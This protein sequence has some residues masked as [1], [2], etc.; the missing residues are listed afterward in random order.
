MKRQYNKIIE[1]TMLLPFIALIAIIGYY[2]YTAYTDYVSINELLNPEMI[3]LSFILLFSVLYIFFIKRAFSKMAHEDKLLHDILMHFQ[4]Y[5][6]IEETYQI[7]E[8]LVKLNKIKIYQF[9][10]KIIDSLEERRMDSDK[11]N[12]SK[13]LFL[14]NMSHEIRTPLNGIVGFTDL[15]RSSD[16]NSEQDEYVEIVQKSSENLLSIINDILDISKIEN[17]KVELECIEFD[18]ILE[19]ESGI[20]SY[21]AKASEKKIDLGFF[22]DPTLSY[23]KLIGDPSKIKQILVNLISNAVKFT[24]NGGKINIQIE[25]VASNEGIS[26]IN[27]S[28]SD[29]GIGIKPEHKSKI[30]MPFSQADNSTSRKFGG[31]GLGLTISRKLIALMG[32]KLEVESIVN[33]GST[34]FFTLQFEETSS[35]TAKETIENV[36]VGYYLPNHYKSKQS[37]EYIKKYI[38]AISPNFKIYDTLESLN[39]SEQP[40]L[41]FVDFDHVDNDDIIHLDSLDSKITLLANLYQKDKIKTLAFDF[42]QTLYVPINFTKIK[43][44]ILNFKNEDIKKDVVENEKNKLFDIQVL[45]AEDNLINQKLI[46]LT[47]EHY[48]A[49]V[50][51]VNNGK[52]AYEKRCTQEFDLILMDYQMP[53]MN[54]IESTQAI[55]EYEQTNKLAHIPIVALTANA[56]K[57]DK[58]R[59]LNAGLDNYISKPIKKDEI[60]SLLHFYFPDNSIKDTIQVLETKGHVDILLCKKDK[61]DSLIFNTLLQKIGFSVDSVDNIKELKQKIQ[62]K[63]YEYVLL[64]KGLENLSETHEISD[65]M[66]DLSIKSILFV[67]NRNSIKDEDYKKYSRVVLNT[68]DLKFLEHLLQVV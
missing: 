64:D 47:L 33:I 55:L 11:A 46:K 49:T 15:L 19:F 31:T 41:L 56:L 66:D 5:P 24:P 2:F 8:M 4:N 14:A 51:L 9:L 13:S 54:G 58:E 30:F 43:K 38:E 52:E 17:D 6:N 7:N 37:D 65:L 60:K 40:E 63:N 50:I 39:H 16:L 32:G 3:L 68:A 45:V 26:T 53:V 29:S 22:I 57:G 28:V 23:N 59:F 34:F 10:K 18:P 44:S 12:Q 48:G 42:Y 35:K 25:K 1:L 36:S 61:I 67:E 21:G 27:F 62:T 20:E